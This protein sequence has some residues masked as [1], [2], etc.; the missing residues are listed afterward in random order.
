[1]D[2]RIERGMTVQ[3]ERWRASLAESG[4]ERVGWK[5][6]LNAPPVMQALELERPVIGWMTSN[7]A[8]EPP[9]DVATAGTTKLGAEPELAITVGADGG[10]AGLGPAIELVDVDQPF[11]DLTAILAADIF[12]H[13]VLFGPVSAARPL[14]G[15]TAR[16]GRDGT[17]EA[18]LDLAEKVGDPADTIALVRGRLEEM[19]EALQPGDRIIAGSLTPIQWAEPGAELVLDM[20]PLGSVAVRYR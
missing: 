7:T 3:L 9:A 11:E 10:V 18:E 6:G 8:L 13:G 2:E 17:P 20:G 16:I 14:E 12:H 4:T 15:I 1:M 19:G 5:V